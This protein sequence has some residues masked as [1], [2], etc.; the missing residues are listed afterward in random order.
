VIGSVEKL[1]QHHLLQ[2]WEI[3]FNGDSDALRMKLYGKGDE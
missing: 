2:Y 3:Q 1:M